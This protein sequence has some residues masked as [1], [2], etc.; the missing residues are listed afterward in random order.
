MKYFTL[1]AI[2]LLAG[3]ATPTE[4]LPETTEGTNEV[5]NNNALGNNMT[6]MEIQSW[7]VTTPV[8]V[9]FQL[10][11][12]N[13]QQIILKIQEGLV[14]AYEIVS[15]AACTGD[16]V[17]GTVVYPA[18]PSGGSTHDITCTGLDGTEELVIHF[19]AAS[20]TG[21]IAPRE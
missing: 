17:S 9:T 18:N 20:A 21:T 4:D 11:S 1:A 15:P 7:A 13:D 16:G 6:V 12:E 8:D 5:P 2:I 14:A 3:C 10:G 19:D